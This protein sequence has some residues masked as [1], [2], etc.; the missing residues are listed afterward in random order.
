MERL[1]Y[2][3]PEA[4]AA[5]G[6]SVQTIRRAIDKGDIVTRYPTRKPVIPVTELQSWLD[7]LPTEAPSS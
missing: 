7:R 4:A 3:L 2:S 6:V 5:I 1:S